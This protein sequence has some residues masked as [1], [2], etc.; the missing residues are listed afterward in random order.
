MSSLVEYFIIIL[1]VFFDLRADIH[2]QFC[3]WLE[4]ESRQKKMLQAINQISL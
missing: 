3:E 2:V 1:H 4:K